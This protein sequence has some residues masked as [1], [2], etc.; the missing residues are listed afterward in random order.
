MYCNENASDA[1]MTQ[2]ARARREDSGGRRC[3]SSGDTAARTLI[4]CGGT[5]H[6]INEVPASLVRVEEGVFIVPR[7]AA[8]VREGGDV[9]PWS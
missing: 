5:H 6:V 3:I 2:S 1:I 9:R 7:R 8:R 4:A